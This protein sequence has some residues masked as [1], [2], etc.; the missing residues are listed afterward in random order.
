MIVTRRSIAWLVA[1]PLAV[2]GRRSRTPSRITSLLRT[3]A[4]VR[5]SS[6]RR[7]T[8]TSPTFPLA[9]ALGTVLLLLALVTELRHSLATPRRRGASAGPWSFALL[10]PAVFV[11]QEYFERWFH[12]GVFPW[13][14]RW[15]RRSSSVFLLQLPFA[16]AA[17][18]LAWVLFHAVALAG[19]LSTVHVPLASVYPRWPPRCLASASSGACARVRLARPASSLALTRGRR[20]RAA[21]NATEDT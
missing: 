9:L 15:S 6:R 5:T 7:D 2:G 14:P 11:C 21:V 3:R 18:V 13:T 16:L 1:L 19:L 10:A 4:P 8:R 20:V 17:Y 12:D